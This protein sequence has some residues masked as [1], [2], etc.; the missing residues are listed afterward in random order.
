MGT[1]MKVK[2]AMVALVVLLQLPGV[3][4]AL[5]DEQRV[6]VGLIGVSVVV[7]PS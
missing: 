6:L 3:S 2:A 4:H 1:K 7:G 5:T